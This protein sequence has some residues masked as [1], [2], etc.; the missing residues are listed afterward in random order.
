MKDVSGGSGSGKGS[1]S[2]NAA[3]GTEGKGEG[4]QSSGNQAKGGKGTGTGNGQGGKKKGEKN[5]ATDSIELKNELAKAEAQVQTEDKTAP[6]TPSQPSNDQKT[7]EAPRAGSDPNKQ[8]GSQKDENQKGT[9][10][11]PV[12]QQDANGA[13]TKPGGDNKKPNHGGTGGDTHL[14]ERPAPANYER[15]LKPGEKGMALNLNDARYVV[16][17]IPAALSSGDDGKNVLDTERPTATTPYTNAPLAPTADTAPP[18]E[19]QLVPPRYR[20]LIK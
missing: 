17:K 20:E 12:P 15:F 9:A 4:G 5:G 7:A 18:D 10:P 14:G 19:R 8:G 11:M 3:G 16:F 13:E 1:A 6:Q 2:A